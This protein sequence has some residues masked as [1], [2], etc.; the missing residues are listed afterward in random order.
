MA[1]LAWRHHE[2]IGGIPFAKKG[3]RVFHY[4]ANGWS[5]WIGWEER[6]KKKKGDGW[7]DGWMRKGKKYIHRVAQRKN[8]LKRMG[9]KGN[10]K[11]LVLV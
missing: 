1:A 3:V 6:K 7:M 8:K 5:N 9:G 4:E 11:V 2:P 10:I